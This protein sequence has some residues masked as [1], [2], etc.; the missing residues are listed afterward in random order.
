MLRNH[1]ALDLTTQASELVGVPR[2]C[3][4]QFGSSVQ[5]VEHLPMVMA[6]S[7]AEPTIQ[8]TVQHT[9]QRTVQRTVQ[10]TPL[11]EQATWA[12]TQ[13]DPALKDRQDK[14]VKLI[15]SQMMDFKVYS[16]LKLENC[17]NTLIQLFHNILQN[18][19]KQQYRKVL[20]S[21]VICAA[22]TG[23]RVPQWSTVL[24]RSRQT[25]YPSKG[26]FWTVPNKVKSCCWQ[27][28]GIHRSYPKT[29]F[30]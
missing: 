28:A 20:S 8:P 4:V 6:T 29:A 1:L 3:N 13:A 7:N 21:D 26:I 11:L 16:P 22:I 9:V 18:P 14:I 30:A 24:R 15:H 12:T 19:E 17:V 5:A 10:H 23:C 25:M 2:Q 27:L